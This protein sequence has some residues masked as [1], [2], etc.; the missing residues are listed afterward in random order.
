MDACLFFFGGG[1]FLITIFLELA[2]E[3]QIR[4]KEIMVLFTHSFVCV[5]VCVCVCVQ[6]QT[7]LCIESYCGF[8]KNRFLLQKYNFRSLP[9]LLGMSDRAHQSTDIYLPA[10]RDRISRTRWS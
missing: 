7:C 1:V 5:C 3:E 10:L 2:A 6:L 9:G 8:S 4:I